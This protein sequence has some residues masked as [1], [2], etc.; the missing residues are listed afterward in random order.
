MGKLI[1]WFLEI[2][3]Y[4]D[5]IARTEPFVQ[6]TNLNILTNL[7]SPKRPLEPHSQKQVAFEHCHS[8]VHTGSVFSSHFR[9][10]SQTNT[11]RN[12][13][14]PL[15]GFREGEKLLEPENKRLE[16][17]ELSGKISKTCKFECQRKMIT[18]ASGHSVSCLG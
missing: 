17:I 8:P 18:P 3:R 14:L 9:H 4:F 6:L 15:R 7:A 5:S 2:P 12:L 11:E 1:A 16:Y 13:P 10:F